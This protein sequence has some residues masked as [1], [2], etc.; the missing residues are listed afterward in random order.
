[1]AQ[2]DRRRAPRREVRV[3]VLG[4][5]VFEPFEAVL[6]NISLSG[7][8]LEQFSSILPAKGSFMKVELLPS[9]SKAPI[10]LTGT[11]VRQ[12]ESGVA[13]QF[14]SIPEELRKLMDKLN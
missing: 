4:R 8:L 10:E 3:P 14:L 7:A 11:V 13:I 1:M 5:T 2:T 9:G 6:A 12:T